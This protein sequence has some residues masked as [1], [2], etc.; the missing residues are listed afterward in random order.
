MPISVDAGSLPNFAF[1]AR[2]VDNHQK[3]EKGP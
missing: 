1:T 3:Q 2:A